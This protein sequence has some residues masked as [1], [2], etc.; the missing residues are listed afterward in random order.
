MDSDTD[1]EGEEDKIEL[2]IESTGSMVS[3][4]VSKI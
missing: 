4:R 2:D 3:S 1:S